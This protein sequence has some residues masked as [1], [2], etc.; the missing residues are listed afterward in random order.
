MASWNQKIKQKNIYKSVHA[1]EME[2]RKKFIFTKCYKIVYK[3]AH[4]F[5]NIL[6]FSLWC[7]SI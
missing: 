3:N 6:A 1:Y 2:E 7:F 4:Y 5:L